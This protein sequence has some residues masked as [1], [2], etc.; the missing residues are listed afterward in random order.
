[1]LVGMLTEEIDATVYENGESIVEPDE[2]L[3]RLVTF[4]DIKLRPAVGFEYPGLFPP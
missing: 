1:M 2:V 4:K 3:A